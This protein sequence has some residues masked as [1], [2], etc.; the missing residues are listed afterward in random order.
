MT[1]QNSQFTIAEMTQED[2]E[3]A[4]VMRLQSWL[5]TYVNDDAGVTREWI[6]KRNKDQM[7]HERMKERRTRLASSKIKAW[8]AKNA[9]GKIIG[10]TTP[11]IDEE[12]NQRVGSLYVDKLY[13]GMGLGSALMQKVIEGYDSARPIVL[14]VVTYNERAKSFYR[15]WG[16][17]EI[18]NSET[19]FADKIPEIM[20]I[21]KGD[22]Q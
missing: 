14:G 4:T 5:D 2:I 9:E 18:P 15:K 3:P 12:G 1:Q 19:M 22:E 6:E 13:H 20:M 7:S 10:A 8:V 11:Y 21:R 17:E 16:F